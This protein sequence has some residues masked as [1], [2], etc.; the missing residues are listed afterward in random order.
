MP[1]GLEEALRRL[2]SFARNDGSEGDV[3]V[4]GGWVRD[5]L[6]GRAPHEVDLVAVDA[7]RFAQA[8]ATRLGSRVV[9]LGATQP[10]FRVPLDEGHID[11]VPRQ[12]TLA[13]DLARR[14]FTVNALALPLAGLAGEGAW[15]AEV[16]RPLVVDTEGGLADLDVGVLRAVR[17][18]AFDEDPTRLWRAARFTAELALGVEEHTRSLMA[19]TVAANPLERVAPERVSVELGRLFAT[20]RA[21]EGVELMEAAGLLEETFPELTE[22]RGLEQRP[23]HAYDVFRHQVEASRRIDALLGPSEP[24]DADGL[25]WREFWRGVEWQDT[26]WGPLREVL[27]RHRAA[28]RLATLL[29][30]VGKPRTVTVQ[31]NGATRF[32]GH[33]EVGAEMVGDRLRALRFPS[34][35]VERVVLL[36]EQHLRPGQAMSPGEPPTDRALYRFHEALGDA[37]PDV[38]ALFLADSLATEPDRVTER[39]PA[40]VRHVQRIIEW[41]PSLP[42]RAPRLVTGHDLMAALDVPPGPAL[43]RLLSSIEEATAVGEVTSR[44]DALHL[45]AR[46]LHEG[47]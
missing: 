33:S 35:F 40:Y 32:F 46:V 39:W 20:E 37:T 29:H 25:L 6:L 7:L 11:I 16:L 9:S 5:V 17:P 3:H 41:R 38:C 47:V 15:T 18:E 22:G 1:I 28:V 14:D 26:R 44:E 36:I 21:I 10:L 2:A 45:A 27:D 8:A 19:A 4:V 23:W 31:P 12:G 30:D 34:A 24:A 13:A 43:G 42:E